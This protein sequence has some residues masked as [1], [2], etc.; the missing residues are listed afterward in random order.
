MNNRNY[1]FGKNR[2][3]AAAFAWHE[4]QQG[5]V[6]SLARIAGDWTVTIKGAAA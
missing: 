1:S 4:A 3:F 2:A 5:A 6:V